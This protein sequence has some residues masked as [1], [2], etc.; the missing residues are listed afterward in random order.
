MSKDISNNVLAILVGL[1]IVVSLVGLVSLTNSSSITGAPVSNVSSGTGTTSLGV[2]GNLI[3]TLTDNA[4][5]LGDLEI[6][7]TK[8]SEEVG[9]FFTVQNDGSVDF[10]VYAYGAVSPF[11]SPTGGADTV[12]NSYYQIHANSTESGTANTTYKDVPLL[13][14]KVLLVSTLNKQNSQDAANIGIKVTVPLDEPEGS[15]SAALTLYVER[16]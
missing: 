3:L 11:D 8:F 1:G 13:A 14:D 15:K 4:I 10:N 7:E 9:D 12:P 16:S 6:G 5:N 2:R